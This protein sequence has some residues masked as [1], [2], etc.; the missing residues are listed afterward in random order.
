[1]PKKTNKNK[2][3]EQAYNEIRKLILNGV[4]P[5]GEQLI[6]TKLADQLGMSR[7]P[8]RN[9][10][11]RLKREKLVESTPGG[12][13]VV[14]S[15]S[16][17]DVAETYDIREVIEGLAVRLLARRIT[18]TEA[19]IIRKLAAR[20]DMPS[21]TL[22]DDLE[23]HS[24][25]VRMCGNARLNEL[26]DAFCLHSMTFDER[27]RQMVAGGDVGILQMDRE[28]DAHCMVAE[29]IINGDANGAEEAIRHYIRHGKNTLIK[30]M[31]GLV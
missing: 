21:A 18:S 10:L 23:F 9:A 16:P 4:L 3:E 20:A 13:T 14:V 22:S 17:V 24:A 29:K 5:P 8:V 27:S 19:G 28:A 25:I 7:T 6:E 15:L 26:V 1:M 12:G 11:I 2:L 30:A 31:M